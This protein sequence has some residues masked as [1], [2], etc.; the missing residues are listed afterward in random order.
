MATSTV[1]N[2]STTTARGH[3][4]AAV[5]ATAALV[6]LLL[7]VLGSVLTA[8]AATAAPVA[9][10][11]KA[12]LHGKPGAPKLL[13]FGGSPSIMTVVYLAPESDGGHKIRRYEATWNGGKTW[14]KIASG[15]ND[16]GELE[17]YRKNLKINKHYRLAVRAVNKKGHSKP[18]QTKTVIAVGRPSKP[19]SVAITPVAGGVHVSWKAPKHDGG[20]RIQNYRVAVLDDIFVDHGYCNVPGDARE[21]TIT[22]LVPGTSYTLQVW[23]SNYPELPGGVDPDPRVS[24]WGDGDGVSNTFVAG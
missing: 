19:R 16:Y 12:A 13:G 23:S 6:V 7:G 11:Q 21:C 1:Q 8:P 2:W 15:E 17:G 24:G 4:R 5:R 3:Q 20:R 14:E 10:A 22:G 18:S 9:P